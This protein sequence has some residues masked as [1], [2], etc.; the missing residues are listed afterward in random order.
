MGTTRA[1]DNKSSKKAA[2]RGLWARLNSFQIT[3]VWFN[4]LF[5]KCGFKS[6]RRHEID[7][8]LQLEYTLL[9]QL[10]TSFPLYAWFPNSVEYPALSLD[11]SR[12]AKITYQCTWFVLILNMRSRLV[13]TINT[14]ELS[15]PHSRHQLWKANLPVSKALSVYPFGRKVDKSAH[16]HWFMTLIQDTKRSLAFYNLLW[17]TTSHIRWFDCST[18]K[19]S[20]VKSVSDFLATIDEL[21]AF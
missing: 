2:L 21:Q 5:I 12:S 1:L 11:P 20:S 13:K 4:R 18:E 6:K 15:W 19:R 3:I 16:K 14:G 9:S 17:I 7:R 10:S 8:Y